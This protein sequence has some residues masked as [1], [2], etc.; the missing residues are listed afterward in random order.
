MLWYV[1]PSV[2]TLIKED[3][4]LMYAQEHIVQWHPT[5]LS[6][7]AIIPQGLINSYSRDKHGEEYK[8]GD[9]VV[10]FPDCTMAKGDMI[11]GD[12]ANKFSS[13]WKA[14]FGSA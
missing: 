8:A 4:V 13:K 10:R 3:Q 11:C 9:L 5:I 6:K 1:L 12:E 14:A 2:W 7:L